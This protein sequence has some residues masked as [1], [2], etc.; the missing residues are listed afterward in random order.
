MA[1]PTLM[2]GGE[3]RAR[4]TEVVISLAIRKTRS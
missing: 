4:R 2:W 3:W 1:I